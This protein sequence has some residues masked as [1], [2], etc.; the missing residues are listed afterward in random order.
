MSHSILI[1]D[2]NKLVSDIVKMRLE[3]HGYRVRTALNGA[4]ALLKIETVAPDL[5]VLNARMPGMDGYEVC[6]RVRKNSA[7]N[8]VRII[9]LAA[10]GER[11]ERT[12][13]GIDDVLNKDVDLLDLPNRIQLLLGS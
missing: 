3:L 8:D 12:T 7:L 13:V 5:V 6:R 1:V 11:V 4:D 9:M 10:G 2:D